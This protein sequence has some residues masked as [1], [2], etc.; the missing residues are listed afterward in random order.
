MEN[1]QQ[2]IKEQKLKLRTEK[3][4]LKLSQERSQIDSWLKNWL[5]NN[6]QG[7]RLMEVYILF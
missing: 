2:N 3:K 4:N 6:T 5:D 1:P 7:N